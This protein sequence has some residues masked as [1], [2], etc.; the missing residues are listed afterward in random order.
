MEAYARDLQEV[1]RLAQLLGDQRT[2]AHLRYREAYTHRWFCRYEEALEA[3]EKGIG[4]S[5][6]AP[7]RS[8]EAL[9]WREV[10]MAARATGD[11]DRARAAL[12]RALSFFVGLDDALYEIHT[13]GNLSTL[14]WYLGEHEQ[15]MN[16][17]REAL[18]RCDET[19]L[20]LQRRLALG[21]VGVAA[22]AA[23]D[24]GLARR[25]LLQSLTIARQ[26]VDRTQEIFCLGHLG[27]LC[28]REKRAA[29]AVEHLQ[30]ALSLAESIDSRTEK[31]WLL[32]GL[33]ETHRLLGN[34]DQA[35]VHARRA[36][37]QSRASGRVYDEGLAQQILDRL[38]KGW[39]A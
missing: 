33:A 16:L 11:Y 1:A 28:V 13:L 25:C 23:G 2:L 8:L 6:A 22:G 21:D 35:V 14:Y 36:L 29:E 9:C 15:A 27:W 24:V 31:S 19:G 37:E 20:P 26:I 5:Q 39:L 7:A 18:A 17:A 30:A 3:A 4:L 12:E 34:L 32:S 38:G 10:G